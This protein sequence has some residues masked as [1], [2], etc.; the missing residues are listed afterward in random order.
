MER[1]AKKTI[2]IEHIDRALRELGFPE[3]VREVV[4]SAGDARELLKS[5][6]KRSGKWES[7]GLSEEELMRQQAELFA[8]AGG[9]GTGA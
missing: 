8:S 2:S 3:Y 4:A 6:E 9:G 7:S 5:R 1:E